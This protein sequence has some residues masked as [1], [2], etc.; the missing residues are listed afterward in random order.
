[1]V[2]LTRVSLPHWVVTNLSGVDYMKNELDFL[3]VL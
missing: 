1:M 2:L 3:L